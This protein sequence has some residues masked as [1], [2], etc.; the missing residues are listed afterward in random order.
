MSTQTLW[1]IGSRDGRSEQLIDNYKQPDIIGKVIWDVAEG[2]EQ[3]WP[4]FHPSEADPDSGY[5]LHPYQ[6]HFDLDHEPTGSYVLAVQYVVIA[7]LLA[8]IE[9]EVNGQKGRAYLRPSPSE[10]G[11]IR[12]HAGLHTSIY[13]EGFC[14]VVIPAKWL[15][16]QG[17]AVTLVSRDGGDYISVDNI[18]KIKRFDRMANGAGFIYQLISFSKLA[19]K[20]D[21]PVARLDVNPTVLYRKTIDGDLAEK[22]NVFLEL[23]ESVSAGY[24]SITFDLGIGQ[25]TIEFPVVTTP[26]GHLQFDLDLKDGE[27][28]VPYFAKGQIDGIEFEKEGAVQR[29]RKWK[30]F[31]TP[32]AHTDIGYTHRQWEVAERL[33]R[34]IDTALEWL[35]RENATSFAYHLDASWV[36]DTYLATRGPDQIRQLI[37]QVKVGKV[38]IPHSYVDLLTQI[39]SLEALIR[40]GEDTEAFLRPEG[41]RAEFTS[42]VDVPSMT[43]SLPAVLQ[44]SGVKY[45]VHANNQDRGPFRLN[46]GLHKKSPFYWEGHAGGKVL[47]WL[48]KMYCELRKVCGSPP[49]ASS[50]ERGLEMWLDE[51]ENDDYEPDAVL[52]YGQEADNTDI[53]PQP[54]A[55]VE[56]WNDT[57]AY[58]KLIPC[59][60][61]QFF[62]YVEAGFGDKLQT[63]KGDGGAYWEDGASSTIVPTMKIREAQAMLPVAER[64]ESLA[65]IHREN[66]AYPANLFTEAWKSTLQY[67]EHTWGAFLSGPDPQ[68]LLQHDQWEVKEQFARDGYLGAKRLLHSAASRHSLNWQTAGREVVAYNPHSW[69]I[70]GPMTVEIALNESVFDPITGDE[71]PVRV[72]KETTTQA[73]VE[74]WIENLPGLSYRRMALKETPRKSFLQGESET[75]M[76]ENQFYRLTFDVQKGSVSSFYDKEL[77]REL[78]D[79]DQKRGFGQWLY[80]KGGEGTRLMGNQNDLPDGNPEILDDFVLSDCQIRH[81]ASG[82]ALTLK[83]TV[84]YGEIEVQWLLRNHAK[85]VE[86]SFRYRKEE[87]FAKEAV[88]VAFPCGLK[89]AEVLSDSQLGW[90]NWDKDELPG[91]CKE[92]LPLQTGILLHGKGADMVIASPDIPLFTVGDIVRGRW[93]KH[94][95]LT[96]GNIFSYVSNN[97]WHTNYKASQ[98]GNI[99]FRYVITSGI[100]IRKDT[101]FRFGWEARQPLYAQRISFQDFRQ[102]SPPYENAAGGRLAKID[103]EKIILSTMKKAKWEGGWILRFQ[104]I[105]GQSESAT[106]SFPDKKIKSAWETDLL[107]HDKER[108]KVNEDGSLTVQVNA[109]S[110]Q[111]VRVEF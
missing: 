75:A 27:G 54:M 7:P 33:C 55:F 61:Q 99:S 80:A 24:F 5:R 62:E 70:S 22:I 39:A 19:E 109:W 49:V 28:V 85:R 88:Y 26:F 72:V 69:T 42:V 12:L 35:S 41:M 14:E 63:V 71:I 25:K 107:E 78:V 31:L 38:G 92:W 50:A 83:G 98:G 8:F 46:G 3:K 110:L 47:V 90:V 108:L 10:S 74:I 16:R 106:M 11:E 48:A 67:V 53:D 86:V 84:P 65:V 34:N 73:V 17:N 43:G 21:E 96:G 76:L 101:A 111:T 37:Q 104:E 58:P 30:V 4:L 56:G 105:G 32:H 60:V 1:S 95:D 29:R 2:T 64:L 59:D 20:P 87:K 81:F 102:E 77:N 97:Y 82:S 45:L 66:G 36:L 13:S 40:N 94:Q 52:L 79:S 44:D 9:L 68:A 18:E 6:I 51:Y 23:N 57:Y 103:S 100:D 89:E 15:C 93:P 91:A